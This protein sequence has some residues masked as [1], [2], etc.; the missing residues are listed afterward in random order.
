MISILLLDKLILRHNTYWKSFLLL[1]SKKKNRYYISKLV[2][3]CGR[4]VIALALLQLPHHFLLKDKIER[5]NHKRIYFFNCLTHLL[6]TTSVRSF[7]LQIISSATTHARISVW[8]VI[9]RENG[10]NSKL[11]RTSV[12]VFVMWNAKTEMKQWMISLNHL[13]K[14]RLGSVIFYTIC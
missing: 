9:W 1:S 6:L 5:L 8:R 11:K 4:Q 10:L 14:T 2:L 13:C 7:A 3:Y 12:A